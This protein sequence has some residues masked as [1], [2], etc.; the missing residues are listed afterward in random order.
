MKLR[1]TRTL[2][3]ALLIGSLSLPAR[4]TQPDFGSGLSSEIVLDGNWIVNQSTVTPG[5]W[6]PGV[7][8]YTIEGDTIIRSEADNPFDILFGLAGEDQSGRAFSVT[9]AGA[10]LSF[11]T[12]RDISFTNLDANGG[13]GGAF[14][15][16]GG[17]LIS[18][19]GNR[20]ITF[21]GNKASYAGS[22]GGAIYASGASFVM[23]DNTGTIRF[24]NNFA[25]KGGGAIESLGGNDFEITNNGDVVFENNKATD[26][27]GIGGAIYNAGTMNI[28]GNGN[29]SFIGNSAGRAGG[30]IYAAS[31]SV[32]I[33][34]NQSVSFVGNSSAS[35]GGAIYVA[36]GNFKMQGNGDILFDGNS[37]VTGGSALYIGGSTGAIDFISNGNI[38]FSNNTG[39][40]SKGSVITYQNFMGGWG[41]T[42]SF[43]NNGVISFLENRNSSAP[44]KYSDIIRLGGVL[45]MDGNKGIIFR[46][47]DGGITGMTINMRKNTGTIAFARNQDAIWAVS[48]GQGIV[49]DGNQNIFFLDGARGGMHN[50]N[51]LKVTNNAHVA[52]LYNSAPYD[53]AVE[54]EGGAFCFYAGSGVYQLTISGNESVVFAGNVHT[55]QSKGAERIAIDMSEAKTGTLSH[56]AANAGKSVEIYDFVKIAGSVVFNGHDGTAATSTGGTVKFSGADYTY[57]KTDLVATDKDGNV[58]DATLGQDRNGNTYGKIDGLGQK[59]VSTLSNT[60]KL[61]GG[62]LQVESG[63]KLEVLESFTSVAQSVVSLGNGVLTTGAKSLIAGKLDFSGGSADI[64]S[65]SRL[66]A[67]GGGNTAISGKDALIRNIIYGG[68]GAGTDKIGDDTYLARYDITRYFAQEGGSTI[69]IG[70]GAVYRLTLDQSFS[71]E[72]S[73]LLLNGT[74]GDV[75]RIDIV[76]SSVVTDTTG[77]S[78]DISSLQGL[79]NQT[80]TT[81]EIQ[82]NWSGNALASGDEGWGYVQLVQ[83]GKLIPEPASA[84]LTLFSLIGLF[85]RR[86]RKRETK[87]CEKVKRSN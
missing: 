20:N 4:A 34:N 24:A 74:L 67:T 50:T 37:S 25:V 85:F 48:G 22:Y 6:I 5:T 83:T 42:L 71:M 54:I 79:I 70:D 82:N 11:A 76:N 66:I 86:N 33:N 17:K 40:T 31:D 57:D 27:T 81:W 51:S 60:A 72:L 65:L 13:N 18:F 56:I 80:G 1:I 58:I 47:N 44:D 69:T 61:Q 63:A 78:F 12:D 7:S 64:R 62:T 3:V 19:Q 32:T 16:A 68:N 41:P 87:Q 52:W 45:T 14:D 29:V 9:A 8:Y 21:D 23:R 28:S 49:F 39:A 75:I 55:T 43:N 53:S 59:A 30:A 10:E 35:D 46:D 2:Q 38:T 77:S 26:A 84:T 36:S 15:L 73:D